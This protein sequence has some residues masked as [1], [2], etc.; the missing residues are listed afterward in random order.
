[1]RTLVGLCLAMFCFV[2]ASEAKAP[3]FAE[4]AYEISEHPEKFEEIELSMEDVD[5][6]TLQK[7]LFR[8]NQES[9]IWYDTILEGD[10]VLQSDVVALTGVSAIYNADSGAFVA[11]RINYSKPAWDHSMCDVDW[12]QFHDAAE[13]ERNELMKDCTPGFIVGSSFVSPNLRQSERDFNAI[14]DF[15]EGVRYY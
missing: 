10:Y 4:V 2:S 5:A 9:Q 8:A 15:V 13:E 1:M 14:E 12:D 6:K 11:Y 7:L 3:K